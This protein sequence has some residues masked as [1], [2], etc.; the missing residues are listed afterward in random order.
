MAGEPEG[1]A[2]PRERHGREDEADD[3]DVD[4]GARREDRR[5]DAEVVAA[6]GDGH[7]GHRQHVAAAAWLA[8]AVRRVVAGLVPAAK[9]R[10]LLQSDRDG[11]HAEK[12][13]PGWRDHERQQREDHARRV[14]GGDAGELAEGDLA[15]LETRIGKEA[16]QDEDVVDVRRD[17]QADGQGEEGGVVIHE[18]ASEAGGGFGGAHH[19]SRRGAW[20]PLGAG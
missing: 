2:D 14:Q 16:E 17:E 15:R 18:R 13:D 7:R 8:G 1:R 12:A 10:D 9:L 6:V 19:R 5:V 4:A 11:Q 20:R 3:G